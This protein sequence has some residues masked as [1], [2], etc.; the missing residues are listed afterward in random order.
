MK[1]GHILN[2]NKGIKEKSEK[3]II[4]KH[5]QNKFDIIKSNKF[6]LII[7]IENKKMIRL[8]NVLFIIMFIVSSHS[9]Q[10][11]ISLRVK[12]KGFQNIFYGNN[13]WDY[14]IAQPLFTPPDEVIINKVKQINV[15]YQY[16]FNYEE[17]DVEL[18][19][20]ENTQITSSACLFFRCENIIEVDLSNYDSSQVTSIYR[21]FR[22]CIKLTSVNC[23]NFN[24]SNVL[25][26]E[27]MFGNCTS[28]KRLNVSS[29]DT[30][31]ITSM[32]RMFYYCS[33][34][35]S[36][37]LSNFY[38]PN[39]TCI[40]EMFNFCNQLKYINFKNA[41]F[42]D[43]FESTGAFL[44]TKNLVLCTNDKGLI[45]II[46]STECA[47]VDC[48]NNWSY[49]QKKIIKENDTCID[50]CFLSEYKYEYETYCY[51]Q[52]PNRTIP[53]KN[54][55]CYE[56]KLSDEIQDKQELVD[57]IKEFIKSGIN[58]DDLENGSDID[59]KEEGL[60]ISITTTKNQKN[61]EINKNK[62]VIDLKECED[63]LKEE[64]N[65]TK[66]NSLCI[67]KLDV[68]QKGMK[69]PKIEYEVYYPLYGDKFIQLN[70]S[71]CKDI[72]IDLLIPTDIDGNIDKYNSKSD[73]YNDICSKDSS[74][75][76][77]D[78]PLSDRK[79]EFLENNLTLCE[80]NCEFISYDEY[81]K[82]VKCSCQIKISL[83][84][85]NDVV[86][87]KEKLKNSFIDIKNILNVKIIKC[88]KVVFIK[89][90][91][92]NNYGCFIILF[93]LILFFI[94]LFSFSCKDY[95]SL[96]KLIYSIA[97]AK[98]TIIKFEDNKNPNNLNS[99][100]KGKSLINNRKIKNKKNNN[101]FKR[102]NNYRRKKN[103]KNQKKKNLINSENSRNKIVKNNN[104]KSKL[105]K[106]K[107]NKEY[108]KYKNLLKYTDSELN[109]LSYEEALIKD[110]RNYMQYYCS[111]LRTNHLLIFT[112]YKGKDYNSRIIKIFLFFYSF[113]VH[114]TINALFFNDSTMH[115][116][117]EDGGSFNFIYQIPQIIYSTLISN[118]LNI[119]IS[120]FSLTDDNIIQFKQV[121]NIENINKQIKKLYQ[122]IKTKFIIFFIITFII[123]II[124]WYYITCFCGIYTN[125][126]IH[127][128]KDSVISFGSSFIYPFFIYLLPGLFRIPAL[129]SKKKNKRCLFRFSKFFTYL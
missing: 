123:L 116:I 50:N 121:K 67:L 75:S 119:I 47:K 20:K 120:Y 3:E 102:R 59:I 103:M 118:F 43:N 117:Y 5:I 105:S 27:A 95:K 28:L 78:I 29:F 37:D 96:K 112:F 49:N 93:I 60:T 83:P 9:K 100:K 72:N 86:I 111:L 127:L 88:Y 6:Y 33:S 55:I 125:T 129:K 113:S 25:N 114:F 76:K 68:E 4:K 101:I 61:N 24:T 104:K 2:N 126:Q 85:I 90:N 8:L 107:D 73:Y 97:T 91:I 15:N 7:K 18:I 42:P 82:K 1:N 69:I 66:N 44:A 84:M 30:S 98:K 115:K 17:N 62:T 38:T 80:E 23:T 71:Y 81:N 45:D 124:F 40:I 10:S 87:D 64:Y 65:I 63:K 22:D 34:L 70:L 89:E 110:K 108:H 36:L 77:I 35:T 79:N 31:K 26:S 106:I 12:G 51:E 41:I 32:F 48:S 52:C 13:S 19:W 74:N 122:T 94:C 39:V 54:N 92:K 99:K 57:N 46:N 56:L 53:N 58:L 109:T 11:F 21:M 16:N 128:I 14:C